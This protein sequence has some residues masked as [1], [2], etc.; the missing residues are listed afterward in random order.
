MGTS[1]LLGK[2]YKLREL[3]TCDGLASR[4]RRVE[5]LLAASIRKTRMI[6][7]DPAAMS[8][9]APRLRFKGSLQTRY[10][11]TKYSE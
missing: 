7:L 9:T 2:P 3:V 4:P 10:R 1:E 5:I 11:K 8:L 6:K